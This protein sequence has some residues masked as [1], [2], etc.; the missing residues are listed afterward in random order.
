M[1]N[2]PAKLDGAKV[3]CWAYSEDDPFGVVE[4]DEDGVVAT[5]QGLAICQYGDDCVYRFSCD[6]DWEVQQD[7]VYESIEE[8]KRL[9]PDQYKNIPVNW[10]NYE[11]T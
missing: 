5:I 3:L 1:K 2:P 8:A 10:Q 11:D 9:L 6:L 4:C 7:G